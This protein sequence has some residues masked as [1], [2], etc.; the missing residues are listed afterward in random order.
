M[1]PEQKKIALQL[2]LEAQAEFEQQFKVS[3]L[4]AL[5]S[6]DAPTLDQKIRDLKKTINLILE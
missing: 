4:E 3:D 1:N 5:L 2:L 6:I